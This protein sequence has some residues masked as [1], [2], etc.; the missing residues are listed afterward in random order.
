M[1]KLAGQ[2]GR[3]V[4]FKKLGI[5]FIV[6]MVFIIAA[7]AASA[8]NTENAGDTG[9]PVYNNIQKDGDSLAYPVTAQWSADTGEAKREAASPGSE[10]VGEPVAEEDPDAAFWRA[11]QEVL[12]AG[13][14]VDNGQSIVNITV[15]ENIGERMS[16]YGREFEISGI[17]EYT[18]VEIIV[19]R[20]NGET[21]VYEILELPDGDDVI[22]AGAGAFSQ[23]LEL[24]YGENNLLI[25]SYRSSEK[26]ESMIQ[27]NSISVTALRRTLEQMLIRVRNTLIDL[28]GGTV[29]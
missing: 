29:K 21:G 23:I 24:E 5:I 27:Y 15:P 17:T 12:D 8:N 6:L 1:Y 26:D 2:F 10:T 13:V 18:D 19:A 22:Y 4:M 9:A 14:P 25:I 16:I 7:S 28:F 3:Y 11:I 20:L